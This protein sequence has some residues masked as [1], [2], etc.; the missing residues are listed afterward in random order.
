MLK[1]RVIAVVIVRDGQVVQ[2][3]GFRHIHV[4]HYDAFHA[5]EAYN[6]WSVDEIIL[7]NVSLTPDSREKF[8]KVVNRVSETCFVPLAAG[9][10]IDSEDYGALLIRHGADK[11]VIN[12]AWRNHPEVPRAL[13][14]RFGRQCIVASIDTRQ[15]GDTR[16]VFVDR[17][18]L[19]IQ[20]SPIDWAHQCFESGAGEIFLNS[21]DHDGMRRGYD[22]E[23]V[24]QLSRDLSIP[25]IAFGGVSTWQHMAAGLDAGAD[26]VAAANIFHYKE[27]ATKQ[28]K[29][30]LAR[31]GYNVRKV[32]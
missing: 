31:K 25:V 30:Y 1:N 2:S 15:V 13:S 24:S 28:A 9:G 19:D 10:W 6:R 21:V 22:K 16:H 32:G 12:T 23:S 26:A 4:I 3:E 17:G 18:R 7:L 20:V 5:I 27:L 11:L 14:R 29:R 8:L